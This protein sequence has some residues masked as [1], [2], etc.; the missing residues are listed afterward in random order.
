MLGTTPMSESVIRY[1][2][3]TR[4]RWTQSATGANLSIVQY[5]PPPILA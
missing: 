4:Q 3:S 1:S 5:E 2:H